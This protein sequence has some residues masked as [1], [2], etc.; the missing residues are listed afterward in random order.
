MK[1]T[2]AYLTRGCWQLLSDAYKNNSLLIIINQSTGNDLKL[3]LTLNDKRRFQNFIF[4]LP[5]DCCVEPIRRN[6]YFT[7]RISNYSLWLHLLISISKTAFPSTTE[8]FFQILPGLL[9]SIL[10]ASKFRRPI[11]VKRV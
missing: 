3:M 11:K 4:F 2:S 7:F 8:F 10:T 1:S 6:I 5:E 9:F